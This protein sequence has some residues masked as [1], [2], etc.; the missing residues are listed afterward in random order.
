MRIQFWNRRVTMRRSLLA[1]LFFFLLPE[2]LSAQARPYEPT[3]D[4]IDKRPS[5]QWFD[6]AKFGIFIH[7][8]VYSVPAY[9]PPA[10]QYAE[11]YWN[12]MQSPSNPVYRYHAEMLGESFA[13]VDFIPQFQAEEVDQRR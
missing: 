11:W 3:W 6:D 1:V 13:Y 12:H 4:S 7:W 9:A 10:T 5:P 8:G 2:S